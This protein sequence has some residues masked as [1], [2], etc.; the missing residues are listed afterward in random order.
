MAVVIHNP[1]VCA[2]Y[3]NVEAKYIVKK[4]ID[5][6]IAVQ[7]SDITLGLGAC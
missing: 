5:R 7:H 3:S 1:Y 2:F 6:D 4:C